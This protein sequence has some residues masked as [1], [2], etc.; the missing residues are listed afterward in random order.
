MFC[1]E[2]HY[3]A[4]FFVGVGIQIGYKCFYMKSDSVHFNPASNCDIS[5]NSQLNHR[6]G[7][8]PLG[9]NAFFFFF[10]FCKSELFDSKN[11]EAAMKEEALRSV[12]LDHSLTFRGRLKL[13]S[14]VH[15]QLIRYRA[16]RK[17]RVN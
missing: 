9:L 1:D 10:F 3:G 7:P 6:H 14:R 8:T 15:Y 13:F 5:I 2:I 4:F 11:R 12:A 16:Y 17:C